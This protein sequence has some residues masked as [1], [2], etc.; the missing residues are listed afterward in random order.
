MS[1]AISKII[2]FDE[3]LSARLALEHPP[4]LL[5]VFLKFISHSCDSWYWMVGLVLLWTLSAQ[6]GKTIAVT[7]AFV[8]GTLAFVVLGIKFL[9]RRK[10]PDG[11]WGQV[12]RV[13]DPH[14]FPSGHAARAGAIAMLAVQFL[15]WWAVILVVIWALLVTYSRVA[16][17]VHY[18]SDVI[19]GFTFG[20]FYALGAIHLFQQL[21][22]LFP[23]V[24]RILFNGF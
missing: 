22:L 9:F 4:K 8:T 20:F 5:E 23:G 1:K 12:Y 16:L 15:D 24:A 11:E 10:R 2:A 14:S 18:F 21:A 17:K 7:T 3:R 19:V 13:N 6:P